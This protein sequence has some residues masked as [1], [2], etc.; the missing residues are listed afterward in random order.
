MRVPRIQTRVREHN[1][2][3]CPPTRVP[4]W[5][6]NLEDPTIHPFGF[7]RE[8]MFRILRPLCRPEN[9]GDPDFTP[10]LKDMEGLIGRCEN[11]RTVVTRF[12]PSILPLYKL[13][14][15]M[16][17][18]R[19]E[20]EKGKR[21]HKAWLMGYRVGPNSEVRYR[22]EELL[23]EIE[24]GFTLRDW[25]DAH[26]TP[27]LIREPPGDPTRTHSFPLIKTK[28]NPPPHDS[29]PD[30]TILLQRRQ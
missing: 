18:Q 2:L 20:Y 6:L 26:M 30:D 8:Q 28:E 13:K 27:E 17:K 4:K 16:E 11:L 19:E 7:K 29:L 3:P 12:L 14:Y 5:D 15:R 9:G 23:K 24:T 22:A 1:P 21:S 25:N 10:T